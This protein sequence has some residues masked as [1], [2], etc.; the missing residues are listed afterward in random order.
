MTAKITRIANLDIA[1]AWDE[2]ERRHVYLE[3]AD[4]VFAGNEIVHNGTDH[5][6]NGG[7]KSDVKG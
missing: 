7:C 3:N 5:A 6:G 4:L 2:A 1:V